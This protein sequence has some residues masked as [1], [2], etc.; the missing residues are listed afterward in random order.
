MPCQT[1]INKL[2]CRE[3]VRTITLLD[4][5]DDYGT[6]NVEGFCWG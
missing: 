4:K 6:S 2:V 3:K 5:E 1:K